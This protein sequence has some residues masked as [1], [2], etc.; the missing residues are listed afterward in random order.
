MFLFSFLILF[1]VIL[2]V[3]FIFRKIELLSVVQFGRRRIQERKKTA[4]FLCFLEQRMNS[5][6]TLLMPLLE[7]LL[8]SNL[9][10]YA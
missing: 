8:H 6:S 2:Y 1:Q 4:I 10:T 3:T 7:L 5:L 9:T